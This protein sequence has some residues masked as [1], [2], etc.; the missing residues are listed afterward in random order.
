VQAQ[1]GAAEVGQSGEPRGLVAHLPLLL[2]LLEAGVW[3]A[4]VAGPC[5]DVKQ[6][7]EVLVLCSNGWEGRC[8]VG[9]FLGV[10]MCVQQWTGGGVE[11]SGL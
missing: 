6:G 3:C 9:K 11:V 7:D 2:L 1:H 10:C 4:V 5:L 8:E